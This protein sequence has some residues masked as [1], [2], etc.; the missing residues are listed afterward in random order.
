MTLIIIKY[1]SDKFVFLLLHYLGM[2]GKLY[3]S[4][5]PV[6][7]VNLFFNVAQIFASIFSLSWFLIW[8]IGS[9][10]LSLLVVPCERHATPWQRAPRC[11]G[12]V[13]PVNHCE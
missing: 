2:C 8:T 7:L 12:I 9:S 13:I 5:M 6:L 10:Y 4:H 3:S 11:R 1:F